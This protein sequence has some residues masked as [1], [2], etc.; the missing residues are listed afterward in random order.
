MQGKFDWSHSRSTNLDR[1][2]TKCSG[3]SLGYFLTVSSTVAIAPLTST[4]CVVGLPSSL[5]VFN[6]YLPEGI[7]LISK[8]PSLSV[9]AKYGVGTTTT[10]PDISGC[11]LH[12]RE[13][14]PRSL[15]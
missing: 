4:A 2:A 10:Y 14:T 8:L 15:N 5:Q 11:T 7:F 1:L 6:V 12:S 13:A 3:S 9:T